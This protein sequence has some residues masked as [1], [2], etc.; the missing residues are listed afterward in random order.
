MTSRGSVEKGQEKVGCSFPCF[1]PHRRSAS[2]ALCDRPVG[3]DGP[4]EESGLGDPQPGVERKYGDP[5]WS[6]RAIVGRS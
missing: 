6:G 4:K 5:C 2:S 1:R 3:I